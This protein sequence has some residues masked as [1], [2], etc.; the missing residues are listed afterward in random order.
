MYF[1]EFKSTYQKIPVE[2]YPADVPENPV[3]SVCVITYQQVDYIHDCLEGILMQETDFPI[4][5]LLGEDDSTDGTREIC[6][7]YAEKYPDKIRL[8]LHH[9]ENNIKINGRATGRFNL[10]YNLY[11]ANGK[12]IA[13]CEG[14]D[15]WTDPLK[16][17][18]QVDY[19]KVND[20]CS[21]CYHPAVI[22]FADNS[23]ENTIHMPKGVSVPTKFDIHEFIKSLNAL[24]ITTASMIFRSAL[25]KDLPDYMFCIPTGD[26]GIK[27]LCGYKGKLGFIGQKPMSLH[28]RVTPGSWSAGMHSK[29]WYLEL[30]HNRYFQWNL[31]DEYSGFKYSKEIHKTTKRR[32]ANILCRM[33]P[34]STKKEFIKGWLK[35]LNA[36][37][38][39]GVK[40]SIGLGGRIILG[41]KMYNRIKNS[42]KSQ[43]L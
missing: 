43:M 10:L 16:L 22:T 23:S 17:Q 28:R 9:R 7:E 32:V 34:Y 11:C 40:K 31:F 42:I 33:Q 26:V 20:D 24:G 14:D 41:D 38:Y 29:D 27:F 2:H 5:I 1:N 30:I 21:L 12:Y 6:L 4:E 25:I 18:K 8:F 19:M 15:Y 37:P 35:H 39:L 3:V 13:L 36:L